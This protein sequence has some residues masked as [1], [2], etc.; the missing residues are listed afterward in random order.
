MDFIVASLLNQFSMLLFSIFIF[1]LPIFIAAI[2]LVLYEHCKTFLAF[3]G[4]AIW[5]KYPKLKRS[6]RRKRQNSSIENDDVFGWF[7]CILVG[8]LGE[9]HSDIFR[10]N[11]SPRLLSFTF[12]SN[13]S[14][15]FLRFQIGPLS[16]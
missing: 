14:F 4:Y 11:N 10:L 7:S 16:F 2:S 5:A 15:K 8:C 3:L 13:I 9:L 1:L 6:L 12:V